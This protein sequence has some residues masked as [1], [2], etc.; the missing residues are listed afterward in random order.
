MTAK[1]K[2]SIKFNAIINQFEWVIYGDVYLKD[3]CPLTVFSPFFKYVLSCQ[4]TDPVGG[5]IQ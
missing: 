1:I 3:S 4:T 5:V 2:N